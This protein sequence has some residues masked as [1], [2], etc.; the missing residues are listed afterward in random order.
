MNCF[1]IMPITDNDP[2]KQGHF[3]RVYE[4]L[5]KPACL[6]AGFDPIRADEILNTNYIAIDIIRRLI[7]C[8]MAICDLSGRNPNVLYELGIRQ[9]FNLPVTLIKDTLTPRIFDISGFRDI[10]YDENLR[11][12]NVQRDVD[13]LSETL[14]NTYDS[15]GKEVN[16]LVTLLGIK[17]AQVSEDVNISKD[18]EVILTYLTA[19]NKKISDFEDGAKKVSSSETT[20]QD[21]IVKDSEGNQIR[22]GNLIEHQKFGKGVVLEIAGKANNPIVTAKFSDKDYKIMTNYAKFRLV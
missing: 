3:S 14:R 18:T 15:K 6:N 13:L 5:I 16:S 20:Q 22:V 1:V 10:E 9:A 11:I 12:D 21:L 17:A 8:E 4:H 2:Y 19:L 7:N